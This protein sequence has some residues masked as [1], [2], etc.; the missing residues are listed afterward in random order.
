MKAF[1]N[2][3]NQELHDNT[4]KLRNLY[5]PTLIIWG[6]EDAWLPAENACCFRDLLP[7]NRMLIY[8]GIGHI[9]ME[10]APEKTV[11]AVAKFL[12]EDF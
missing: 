8:D 4:E 10:E 11:K 5:T 6:S 3:I 2:I 9:P 7:N 1:F 12:R